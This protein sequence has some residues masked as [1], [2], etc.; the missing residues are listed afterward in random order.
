[1]HN[2]DFKQLYTELCKKYVAL[3]SE[4]ERLEDSF[5]VLKKNY[6]TSFANVYETLNPPKDGE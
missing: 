3:E 1:M 2:K 4:M 6:Y 5:R